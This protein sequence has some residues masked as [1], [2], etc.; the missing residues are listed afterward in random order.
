[1]KV[2]WKRRQLAEVLRIQNGYAFDA[3]KFNP[4][5]GMPLVRIRS[6]KLGVE[7]ET[8]FDGPYDS[9]YIVN[10]GDL[11]IGMDGEFG[12]FE[13]KGP[14]SLLNQ[15]VCRLQDFTG[16]LIPRFLLYGI[17]D[18]LKEIEAATGFATVKHL[19]SKQVLGIEFPVP[20]LQEQHRIV[21]IL[22]AAFDGI[23]TAKANAEQ[24]LQNARALFESQLQK[25]FTERGAGWVETTLGAEI[26]LLVGFA[27]KS[28]NYSASEGD[29]PLLRGDNIVQGNLRWDDVRRWSKYD[30]AAYDRYWLRE[31]DVVLAMDRPWVKAGLKHSLITADDL[32]CLLVQRT[33]SLRCKSNLVSR[34][35]LYLV[36]NNAFIQ[37]ILGVQTGIGVPHISGQQIKDFAFAR[38]PTAQQEQI[39]ASLDKLSE[40]TQRLESLYQQKLAALEELKKSLLHQAFSGQL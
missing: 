19:S 40:E 13:W 1:M 10:A 17:N 18:Y 26:D 34:F 14:P 38:P 27:F 8:W 25:V 22:D 15:R 36:R 28:A 29:I 2:G 23:A 4:S 31:N 24:N 20:P 12:C 21:A 3:K 39:A 7:T 32:P 9:R 37:H 5:K 35:L 16:E 11:L 6:L 33:A 30:T